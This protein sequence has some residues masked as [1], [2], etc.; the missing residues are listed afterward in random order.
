MLLHPRCDHGHDKGQT[1]KE[2][3]HDAMGFA[4]TAH[5]PND[6]NETILEPKNG[7]GSDF[8]LVFYDGA[9]HG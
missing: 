4:G 9:K 3:K 5:G 1:Y 2:T 6:K 7:Y 8:Y